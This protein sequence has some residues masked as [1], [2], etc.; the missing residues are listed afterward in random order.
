MKRQIPITVLFQFF[1]IMPLCANA[2]NIKDFF[3]FKAGDIAILERKIEKE[4]N[5][6]LVKEKSCV[7]RYY[8]GEQKIHEQKVFAVENKFAMTE[9]G[10]QYA[11]FIQYYI[12]NENGI[13]NFGISILHPEKKEPKIFDSPMLI[14]KPPLEIGA[15]WSNPS[16]KEVRKIVAVGET[17]IT[18]FATYEKCVKINT[19]RKDEDG[20]TVKKGVRWYCPNY[21]MV[22]LINNTYRKNGSLIKQQE[23]VLKRYIKIGLSVS[24]EKLSPS[25]EA[26]IKKLMQLTK[27][28][29]IGI[30]FANILSQGINEQI[31]S[32]RPDIPHRFFSIVE[33]EVYSFVEKGM[34]E[35]G[36]L[37]DIMIAIFNK[38]YTHQEI[39]GLIDFYQ[40]ELGQKAVEVMPMLLNESMIVGQ[41]WA[42][43]MA[44]SI[45]E[46]V[47]RR[48]KEEGIELPK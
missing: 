11:S 4:K 31:K 21:G 16:N 19:E 24:A 25:K 32:L 8:L 44:P 1:L 26:D 28:T 3:P 34:T 43:K 30:Q 45:W 35:K 18:P 42:Q 33:E 5:G 12:V 6:N 36:G 20:S 17:V 40:T 15:S 39:K 7:Y 27:A 48:L 10:K 23:M 38:Y 13:A 29:D 47:Q 9:T 14:L 41:Q 46:N 22:K 37:F 2:F